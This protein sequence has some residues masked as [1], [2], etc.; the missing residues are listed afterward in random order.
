MQNSHGKNKALNWKYAIQKFTEMRL[1]VIKIKGNV[2]V[3]KKIKIKSFG[4]SK[5]C[6]IDFF[7][8]FPKLYLIRS[9]FTNARPGHIA[10]VLKISCYKQ[11]DNLYWQQ[12]WNIYS[13][14][15]DFI[16]NEYRFH[17][18]RYFFSRDHVVTVWNPNNLTIL[19]RVHHTTCAQT[20]QVVWG[21]KL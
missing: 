5:I 14:E 4:F 11:Y 17:Y 18:D 1:H 19:T 10:K 7:S 8:M 21:Y 6:I 12:T 3:V 2:H 16:Q 15:S 20:A 9:I 13:M